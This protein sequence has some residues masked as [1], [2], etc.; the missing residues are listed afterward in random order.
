MG[1]DLWLCVLAPEE[2]I[3]GAVPGLLFPAKPTFSRLLHVSYDV[4]VNAGVIESYVI[5]I[6]ASVLRSAGIGVPP[7]AIDHLQLFADGIRARYN[8]EPVRAA[9]EAAAKAFEGFDPSVL[10][11]LPPHLRRLHIPEETVAN[12]LERH[13]T[14]DLK[15]L[16][17][18]R[19]RIDVFE[20]AIAKPF[21]T[22]AILS[23][24]FFEN[25]GK[26]Q[27]QLRGGLS[28][29][30]LIFPPGR[31]AAREAADAV[32]RCLS[33]ARIESIVARAVPSQPNETA[34]ARDV[35][36]AAEPGDSPAVE[37][38]ELIAQ[39]LAAQIRAMTAPEGS[40]TYGDADSD[41]GGGDSQK[42]IDSRIQFLVPRG[43]GRAGL[44]RHAFAPDRLRPDLERGL[45]PASRLW[46]EGVC[47]LDSATDG[48]SRNASGS[49]GTAEYQSRAA[50]FFR[51]I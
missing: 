34:G 42:Q 35:G 33:D 28:W 1:P 25:I 22:R 41:S 3:D 2:R 13:Y 50:R 8:S 21:P 32:T 4:V 6:P 47:G 16:D 48:A 20:Q 14:A 11:K 26:E 36:G 27:L 29:I 44:P 40:L 46:R 19:K 43:R 45:R 17:I 49:D 9:R 39:K 51:T 24:S 18:G 31:P 23:A 10:G 15:A 38:A 5:R 37:P 30:D 7:P 12:A